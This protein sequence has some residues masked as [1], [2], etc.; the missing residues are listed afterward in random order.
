MRALLARISRY[1]VPRLKLVYGHVTARVADLAFLRPDPALRLVRIGTEY[2]GR[3]CCLELLGPGRAAVCCGAGEDVSFDVALNARW[4]MRVICVDP[5]PRAIAHVSSLLD[6]E[7]HGRPMPIEAG[8]LSYD[9]AGFRASDFVFIP[10]AVWSMDG[11]L[12]LFAPRD[13][14]HVSYSAVNLQQTSET[15]RVPA[16]TIATILRESGVSRVSLLKLDIEGA[17]YEVLRSMLA[18]G[19]LP[20]Q[21]L[22]EFDQ[23]NQPLT[24]LFWIALLRTFRELRGMGYR[25][26]HREGANCVFVLH[27][28]TRQ[29][30]ALALPAS[31]AAE[32]V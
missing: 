22:V 14:A 12:E 4:G 5:T 24:L 27:P 8:P 18:A 6:A 17:E 3:W 25:M 15:I 19:I 29:P 23:I 7:R 26:V 2:G 10:H 32:R 31:P 1:L 9:L 20:D 16:K 11:T 13:P 30:A 21:V 28:S